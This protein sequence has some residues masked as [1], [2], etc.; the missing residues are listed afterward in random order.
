M[1]LKVV[2]SLQST[3][4]Y[5]HNISSF[6]HIEARQGSHTNAPQAARRKTGESGAAVSQTTRRLTLVFLIGLIVTNSVLLE[7]E[8][9]VM[10]RGGLPALAA[11]SGR[12]HRAP[13]QQPQGVEASQ[14]R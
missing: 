3:W 7:G 10:Q 11:G 5:F 13:E 4:E 9:S 14:V 2:G 1:C 12:H 6:K 8:M